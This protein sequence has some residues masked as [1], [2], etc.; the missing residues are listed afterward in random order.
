MAGGGGGGGGEGG[1]LGV[2]G[3][4]GLGGCGRNPLNDKSCFFIPASL[5]R[6]LDNRF[7]SIV[8]L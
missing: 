1:G 4:I 8:Y 7:I 3:M 2:G 6:A 5:V